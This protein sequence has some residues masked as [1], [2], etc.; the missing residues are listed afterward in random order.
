MEKTKENLA[1]ALRK[2][3]SSMYHTFIHGEYD[4]ISYEGDFESE[5]QE[6]TNKVTEIINKQNKIQTKQALICPLCQGKK[7]IDYEEH[8]MYSPSD[9]SCFGPCPLCEEKGF[10]VEKKVIKG[11]QNFKDQ[12]KANKLKWIVD[13]LV[14]ENFSLEHLDA[15]MH[16]VGL[17][18]DCKESEIE[19]FEFE[20]KL[21][22][23]Y[24]G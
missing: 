1:N 2:L 18:N 8:G 13:Y 23:K 15:I 4:E 19:I 7:E 5:I 12:A 9:S 6:V 10:V 17:F 20:K 14:E 22:Q 16:I 21:Y 24:A 3:V 11:L